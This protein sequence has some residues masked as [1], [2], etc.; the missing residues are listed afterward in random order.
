MLPYKT[1]GSAGSFL[2][3]ESLK[4]ATGQI[5]EYYL[6]HLSIILTSLPQS[7]AVELPED[8]GPR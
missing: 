3:R 2:Q 5:S 7:S 6:P 8:N 4:Q 1:L